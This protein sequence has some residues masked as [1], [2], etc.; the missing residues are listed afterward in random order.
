MQQNSFVLRISY[1]RFKRTVKGVGSMR[2]IGMILVWGA[3]LLGLTGCG[4][5][6]DRPLEP[7]DPAPAQG[8]M[9]GDESGQ[10][11]QPVQ[12]EPQDT[13]AQ[14]DQEPG[15][16]EAA[17]SPKDSAP[18]EESGYPEGGMS[19]MPLGIF[20]T[21]TRVEDGVATLLL[22]N[23]SGGDLEYAA[24][25]ALDVEQGGTWISLPLRAEVAVEDVLYR[26]E[27]LQ[28]A[29]ISCNL[30]DYGPLNPGH[31]RLHFDDLTAE[32]ELT[33]PGYTAPEDGVVMTAQPEGKEQLHI[34]LTHGGQEDTSY[35]LVSTLW[36]LE[37]GLWQPVE[38]QE[39]LGVCGVADPLNVGEMVEWTED[40]S[41]YGPLPEGS[42]R[43]VLEENHWSA[44]FV[45]P[46]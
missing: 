15:E 36:R 42:Y 31:Y 37:D 3:L 26:L 34:T 45:L 22:E 9:E 17:E 5:H 43:I 2:R 46:A 8:Q 32:F 27:D 35:L 28:S 4:L 41:R 44:D 18:P 19:L 29:S 13:Q 14:P 25:T 21:V 33:T 39:T 23:Q 20:L 7:T 12:T 6:S 38:A 16:P 11:T 24:R 30:N 40:L 10:E 1:K